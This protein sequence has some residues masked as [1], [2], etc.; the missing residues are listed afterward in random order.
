MSGKRPE[1][2]G[3]FGTHL[4]ELVKH[5]PHEPPDPKRNG[6]DTPKSTDMDGHSVH[7]RLFESAWRKARENHRTP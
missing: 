3:S 4:D 5:F 2:K 6:D 1:K 7:D